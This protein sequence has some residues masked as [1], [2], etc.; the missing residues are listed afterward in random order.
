M[1]QQTNLNVSPY[2]DDFA[3][4]SNYHKVL[5]KPGYPVQARELTGLQSIL[6]NQIEKFGQHFFKEGSKVIPGNTAYSP[7]YFA[8][9]LNN[10]HLGVPVNYYIEQLVGRKIIGMSTGVTAIVNQVLEATESERGNLTI[11]VSYISSGVED[12]SIKQFNDGEL[13][14]ADSDITSDSS[15]N[16]YIPSGESFASCIAQNATST[17]ASFSISNGVYFIRGN[18]VNVHDETIILSQYD[19]NPS[20][21][22]GLRIE[23]D[24]LNADEDPTLADNS[25]GFNNY[26]APGADRL[27]ISVSLYSKPLDDFNDS[28]FIELATVDNGTLTSQKVNPEYNFINDELARRT[29]EESGDYTIKP[30]TITVRNSLNNGT[31]NNGIF[32]D[33]EST[34]SGTLAADDLAL[35]QVSP[36]KA[37]VKGHE[38]ETISSTFLDCEKPRTSK[39]LETQGVSYN[40]GTT[41]A[42]NRVHGAPVI[43]IGNTYIVSLRDRRTVGD[44]KVAGGEI[45]VARVYDHALESGSYSASN[46]NTNE[47]DISLYDVQLSTRITLNQNI[48]LPVPTHI[49]GK[50][51]GATGYLMNAVSNSTSMDV[52]G[53]SGK[54]LQNE[55]FIFSRN[56]SSQNPNSRV[57]V[58]VT[59]YGLG[60]VKQIYGGPQLGDRVGP[61]IG[62]F[63]ADVIQQDAFSFGEAKITEIDD[64]TGICS[65]TC[66][67]TLF[68]GNLK[69][70]NILSFGGLGNNEFSYARITELEAAKVMITGVTTVS[71]VI[72]GKIPAS[73]LVTSNLKLVTSPLSASTENSLFTLMP[74]MLVSDVDL[75]D[76]VL[77]IRKTQTV[78][79]V[80]GQLSSAL[81]ADT[82]EAFLAY[83]EE[84]YSLTRA[85]GTT[86]ALTSDMFQFSSGSTLLQINTGGADYSGCTLITTLQKSKPS[87]KIK[88]LN[89]VN[90]TVIN[91][92]AKAGSGIGATTLNDGLVRGDFPIG[93]R[94]QDEEIVLN[95]AD[96]IRIHGIYESLDTSAPSAPK[97]TLSTLNGPTAKTTDL[98][99]GER[100]KGASSGA[101]AIV[102]ETLTDAQISYIQ[103]NTDGFEEGEV[104]TFEESNVQGVVTTLDNPSRDIS[105]HYTFNTGQRP[106]F[107]DYGFIRRVSNAKPPKRTIRVYFANGYYDDTDDGDITTKNSYDTW[108][109][110]KDIPTINGDKVTDTID[111]RPKVGTYTVTESKRSPL[112]FYGRN[113]ASSG[114]S[115]KNI[116][117]SD[118][119]ITTNF[120]FYVGRVD[121][122]FLDKTGKFQVQYGDPSE[123][124]ER[125]ITI[126]DAIEIGSV[127][128]PPYLFDTDDAQL[129]FM[130]HKRY[131]MKDIK[132]LE[133][134]IKSLEYYTSLSLLETETANMFLPD[135]D[136]MNKFKSGFYVDNFTSLLPQETSTKIKNSLDPA[137]K[138]LRPQH[139]TTSVDLITG[140]VE[141]VASNVDRTFMDPE[142]TNIKKGRDV[143]T[144]DYTEVEWLSQQFATRTESVTPFLVSFWQ[145]KVKLSPSS[146][147][148][149]DTAR[150]KAKIIKQ[151]GNFAGVTAQAMQQFGVDPQTGQAPIV[152]NAWETTWT[153]TTF[154]DR[155]EQRSEV[156]GKHEVEE[157]IKAG[158]I[159]GGR[160]RN[161]SQMVELTTTTTMQDNI[162]DTY[163]T[164]TSR[165]SGTRKVVTEQWDNESIGDKVVSRDLVQIMRSRNIEFRATK[166]KPLTQMYPFFDGVKVK[167]YCTPK[168]MEITMQS[169]TFQVGET[170][171]GAIPG[172]GVQAEGT[173]KPFI[174]FRVAQAN[175]REGPFNAPT[176]VFKKNPYISQVGATGLETFL[177]T[178]GTVQL[179][180]ASGG[181]TDLP[182]TYSSTTTILNIDTKSLSE[183]AQ[184][185]YFGYA[186]TGMVL[187][188]SSSG[189]LAKI[190][191]VRLITD[192]GANLIGSFYIPNPNSG[193]HPKFE[194]GTKTF[195]L[196][197]NT[198]NDQDNTDSFGEDHYTATGTLETVQESI[199]STR[200]A[201]IE[202]KHSKQAK[203][204][205]KLAGSTVMKTTAISSET[206]ETGR[207]DIWYDPLAQSFQVTEAQGIFVTSCDIYFKSKDDMDIPMTFQIR[208]MSGG[209]P[210]QKILPFSEI[211]MDPDNIK[212]SS[213]GTVAT[214]FTFDAPVYLEGANQEYAIALSSWS[215]KYQV[216]ISR[217]GESDLLT[218]EFIS[219]QPYLGS[220][221]KSQN[222]S[223]WEPS[224]WEDLKFK[225]R[226]AEFETAGTLEL[227]NPELSQGNKQIAK[228]MPNPININSR[229]VRV[230]FGT[231]IS[232]NVLTKGNTVT[233]Q[234]SNATG[235]FLSVAGVATGQLG[236]VNSG[237]GFF[238]GAGTS[239]KIGI[240][241]TNITA[242][243]DFVTA[244][245]VV[246]DGG[247]TS[248]RVI[249]S[250]S[251]YQVGD[252][253]GIATVGVGTMNVGRNAR[254][255]I[256]NLG[257]ANELLLENVQGNF[258]VGAGKTIMFD[259][260]ITGLT[261]TLGSNGST[262]WGFSPEKL[263]VV[264]D[265]LHFTIDHRNHGMHH[266][267]N[268]VTISEATSD[269]SPTRLSLP[270]GSSA[271][272]SIAVE[273]SSDFENFEGVGVA[274]TNPGYVQVGDEI[275][276]YTGAGGGSLTG[277]TRGTDKTNYLKGQPVYK[278]EM[279]GVSL[280]R[281]NKTHLLSDVTDLDPAPITFDSYTIKMNQSATSGYESDRSSN[282]AGSN[283]VLYFNDTRSTGGFDVKGTQN[284]PFQ[285]ISPNIQNTTVPGTSIN[286][287]LRTVS[288]TSLG[289]G[290]GQGTD[291]PFMDKGT[292]SVTLNASNYLNSTRCIASRVNETNNAVIK[293][294]SGDRSMAMTINLT[295]SD[296]LLT[297]VIDLERISAILVSNRVDA[298][299]SNYKTDN[300]VNSMFDDPTACQYI[301]KENTLTN[302]A[303][304]IKIIMNAH[305]NEYSDIRAF[306][307]IS[308]T[309]NFDPIF[310]PFPGYLNL[311]NRGEVLAQADSDGRPDKYSPKQ[312]AGKFKEGEISFR[313]YTFSVEDLPTFK[314]YRIK[315]VMTSTDQTWVPKASELRV[316]TMA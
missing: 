225:I 288:A 148:W 109:Y 139:Y 40:T 77:S 2:F 211:V 235:D 169:G 94:V 153:G 261:T 287:T 161:H 12:S 160:G 103:K 311:N 71:G 150:I 233:Q 117:A 75:S 62:T 19:A 274:A 8:V 302:S 292:E 102:A 249:T 305:I 282:T 86:V 258:V 207:R 20:G 268:R 263:T 167:R 189:A 276:K 253:L 247:I 98:I 291:I 143:V 314:H 294:F 130:K 202:T 10:T 60:D 244:D 190:S 196:I 297:P 133:D 95:E 141:G 105:T 82:N 124:R 188:G 66:E 38:V 179:A 206:K 118:E 144:L 1:A 101:V 30:F 108:D 242:G 125:P 116:L 209:V 51:S 162:R 296:P 131:R 204:A 16:A 313:E 183:Q 69:V 243:G 65:V 299:I 145:A 7:E 245:V 52:Y 122:I 166:C 310:I 64:A 97:M 127:I 59:A 58:A 81:T 275:I 170:V 15:N 49:K 200:N 104:V 120:S 212:T 241:L 257:M 27:K 224:Q 155:T 33:G 182:S 271:S 28:N 70:N 88:R 213:T 119:T 254:F 236:I 178:P 42:L 227:Y 187:R 45:G 197:D 67:N 6:Q 194:T 78:S 316:I 252:V 259:N 208:T 295:T 24:I 89:R 35:Y 134:R 147:T 229:Q 136:G 138:E 68:P 234:G 298:P 218:D 165:R 29:Y 191:N 99:V 61:G 264:N 114:N 3:E 63:C 231:A 251:G 232:D 57:A 39:K 137:L 50:Y 290:K 270:Y 74:K 46:S 312:D 203:S 13:L 34:P 199:I 91:A 172:I 175:H 140:P 185:D 157:I 21:R 222:A 315:F 266:E 240:A 308:D 41:L 135:A 265:G 281:I 11:Y 73:D 56:D 239:T 250:G 283:P 262:G 273:S 151:E 25:K 309:A 289:D 149:V 31:G 219:Q 121:R 180:S 110:T 154:S 80:G 201:V 163:D 156:T 72:E 198:T 214:T 100:I 205:K 115:A 223:T 84:R 238:P 107:Y 23:E 132:D 300:R 256:A 267:Q 90:S 32:S 301:S 48:T 307:A 228:L 53:T 177:G 277:I 87:A 76:A 18:F 158:W 293:S 112:E 215:T 181:A 36:G 83:D 193:N 164:G 96:V 128:L 54:F 152:W 14:I 111:I 17:A 4:D 226:R 184:G 44:G 279:G 85:D 22:I 113:F 146:D 171:R 269:I 220:L 285:I 192:L 106:S 216:F 260:P 286:A 221:F 237:L 37:Y 123:K 195:T 126:D 217:I 129:S 173:D 142:G 26:A 255:S 93:T 92:S 168:L 272:S 303:T 278:Y 55:P 159:N 246:T 9:E 5:F 230:G 304:Q 174:K 43:G 284:I 210:T 47:W 280:Q 186:K 176:A 79:I 248:A 306:Y